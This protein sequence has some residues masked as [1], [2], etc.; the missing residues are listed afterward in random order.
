VQ[1]NIARPTLTTIIDLIHFEEGWR[2]K[3]Y[4]CTEGYPTVG[5]GFKIGPKGADIKLYQFS[6]PIEAGAAWLSSLLDNKRAEMMRDAGISSA[7]ASCDTARQAVLVSMAYQMG[8]VGLA[9][10][11]NTLKMISE[12]R[13]SEAATGMLNSRWAKQTPA[14]AK[15]HALQMQTGIW[16]QEYKE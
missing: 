12:K 14:R 10:F 1:I 13:W 16:A 8:V 9:G 6:L 11:K 3:P 5:Y 15:R 2:S 7:M 4:I